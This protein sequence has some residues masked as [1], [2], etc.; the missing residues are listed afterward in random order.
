VNQLRGVCL[1]V[2]GSLALSMMP[3][4]RIQTIRPSD[5]H[6]YFDRMPPTSPPAEGSDSSDVCCRQ[7]G[8]L[9]VWLPPPLFFFS[10]CVCVLPIGV[11]VC[12]YVQLREL[13]F[14]MPIDS[15]W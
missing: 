8:H 11:G 9:R 3:L 15:W 12:K 7:R 5:L 10:V 2:L 4:S 14:A 13:R 1:S 6:K